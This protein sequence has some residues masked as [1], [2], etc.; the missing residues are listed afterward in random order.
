MIIPL[1]VVND[2]GCCLRAGMGIRTANA[3]SAIY[4]W[5]KKT[6][7]V[8]EVELLSNMVLAGEASTVSVR[9]LIDNDG[10]NGVEILGV[11]HVARNTQAE[12]TGR[13]DLG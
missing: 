5:N 7:G 3:S 1:G 9:A 10:S 6:V 11:I 13:D 4:R 2:Y 8:L 12:F